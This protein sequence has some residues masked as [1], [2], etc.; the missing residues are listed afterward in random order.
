METR[1]LTVPE[2]ATLLRVPEAT[3][4]RWR[5]V[6]DGPKGIRIGKHVRYE[7]TEVERWLS[8]KGGIGRGHR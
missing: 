8:E 3:V 7:A 2:L 1:F 6:G 4:R 5:H